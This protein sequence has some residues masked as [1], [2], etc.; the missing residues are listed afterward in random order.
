MIRS[1]S[2]S[3]KFAHRGHPMRLVRF[4]S[5][6]FQVR[7]SR[8]TL[9]IFFLTLFNRI[10]LCVIYP[11]DFGCIVRVLSFGSVFSLGHTVMDKTKSK[12]NNFFSKWGQL[13]YIWQSYKFVI[14]V[15]F[16]SLIKSLYLGLSDEKKR[17]SRCVI[18]R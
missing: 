16:F 8:F 12:V 7:T 2:G 14:L 15:V 4:Y 6:N 13:I 3:I 11:E 1:T 10:F 9:K 18:C 17:V 5:Q